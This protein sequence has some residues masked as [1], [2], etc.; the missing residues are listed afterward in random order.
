[1][2]TSSLESSGE[3]K[4]AGRA[5]SRRAKRWIAVAAAVIVVAGGAT[6][7]ASSKGGDSQRSGTV[8]S[9]SSSA[10]ASMKIA[11]GGSTSCLVYYSNIECWGDNSQGQAGNNTFTSPAAIG[12]VKT[13][14]NQALVATSVSAGLEQTCAI[15]GGSAG[16]VYCW[17]RYDRTADPVIKV[18]QT[19]LTGVTAISA[20]TYGTCA[21]TSAQQLWCWGDT[22]FGTSGDQA[23]KVDEGP[24]A[25]VSL[26]GF[27]TACTISAPAGAPSYFECQGSPLSVSPTAK[28]ISAGG[29]ISSEHQCVVLA[30]DGAVKCWGDNTYGQLGNGTTT[31]SLGSLQS[32]GVTNAID[33]VAGLKHTCAL[34]AGSTAAQNTVKCWGDYSAAQTG[35]APGGISKQTT[36]IEVTGLLG[37][38]AISTSSGSSHTCASGVTAGVSWF[39]CWGLNTSAQVSSPASAFITTPVKITPVA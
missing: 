30:A 16:Y 35:Q 12:K 27:I 38:T 34:I 6:A 19:P 14:S 28:A 10:A 13:S 39:K 17:G 15:S 33:V 3:N 26:G 32:T 20:G 29:G 11:A 2:S 23:M 31:A 7:I 25:A 8:I 5:S 4:P 1:L 22:G 24:V 9:G 18:D 21:I 36:P 37:A